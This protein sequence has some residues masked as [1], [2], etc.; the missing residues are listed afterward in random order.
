MLKAASPEDMEEAFKSDEAMKK[1]KAY[2][3]IAIMKALERLQQQ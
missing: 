2:H 1:V 3:R